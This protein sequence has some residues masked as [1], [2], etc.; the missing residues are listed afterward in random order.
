MRRLGL[1]AQSV[2]QR[3][4]NPCVGGSIPPRATNEFRSIRSNKNATFGWRFC[5][6]EREAYA[7][8]VF[9]VPLVKKHV[10]DIS[11]VK[12]SSCPA[13][14]QARALTQCWANDTD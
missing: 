2:E 1:V 8:K 13:D 5:L 14:I 12:V 7:P 3:I 6:V 10:H 4:E 9:Q 11:V